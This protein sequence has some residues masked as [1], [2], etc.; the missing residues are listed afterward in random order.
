MPQATK[1]SRVGSVQ[2]ARRDDG[3]WRWLLAKHT[4]SITKT[5]WFSAAHM[6]VGHPKCGR[7]HGH[8]YR[9][10]VTVAADLHSGSR[11]KARHNWV[12]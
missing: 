1:G 7:M 10:D 5:Y 9:V 8:N 6:L 2:P 11:V 12:M 3:L 4:H